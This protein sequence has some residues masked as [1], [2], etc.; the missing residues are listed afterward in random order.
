MTFTVIEYYS[1]TVNHYTLDVKTLDEL[2]ALGHE[3]FGD[4][5]M[6]IDWA[7]MTITVIFD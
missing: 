1:F 2:F 4:V 3:R 7:D 6:T 5:P